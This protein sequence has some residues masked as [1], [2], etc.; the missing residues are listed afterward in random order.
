MRR[1]LNVRPRGGGRL[2]LGL[3]PLLAVAL[4]YLGASTARHIENPRDK[5]LPTPA[6]MVVAM[7]DM[8]K[9]DPM[10]GRVPLFEDTGASLRRLTV[11]LVIATSITLVFGLALG[12]LPI[13][14]AGFGPLVAAI[15]VIPPIA[16]LPILFIVFGLGETA[17]ITLIVFGVTPFMVRDLAAHV[18]AIPEE[19]IVKAQ[20]LG[21]STW[22][23][24]L[25][26][27]LPQALPRLIDSVRLSLG[28]AWVFLISAEA[29]AADVG[30]GYRIFL[31]RRYLAMD[32][33]LPYVAWI[34]LLAVIMDLLLVQVSRRAFRWAHPLRDR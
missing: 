11:A 10:T 23:T 34:S 29:I 27:A 22:Q 14:R 5:I 1:L 16:V 33:I 17:K 13:V 18:T 2:L 7:I 3:L 24:A 20:S 4:L 32:I 31:V 30:L 26:V 12:L 21:A 28:P 19:Q 25:Q 6:A 9:V 15:A 8:A